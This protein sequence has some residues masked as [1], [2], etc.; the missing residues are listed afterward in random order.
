MQVSHG[1]TGYVRSIAQASRPFTT[2]SPDDPRNF[3][4]HSLIARTAAALA[5][6]VGPSSGAVH[7]V[8]S[9]WRCLLVGVSASAGA[10]MLAPPQVTG[11]TPRRMKRLGSDGD[12]G[13]P[14]LLSSARTARRMMWLRIVETIRSA[15]SNACFV[16][17]DAQRLVAL[18]QAHPPGGVPC[19]NVQSSSASRA[20][21]RH[22]ESAA[23]APVLPVVTPADIPGS[24]V[25]A[26]APAASA[27]PIVAAISIGIIGPA[28]TAIISHHV[29]TIIAAMV[30][31]PS[32]FHPA[33]FRCP[34]GVSGW[35]FSCL[36]PRPVPLS[37]DAGS[38]PGVLVDVAGGIVV[39]MQRLTPVTSVGVDGTSG[40]WDERGSA[41]AER[42]TSGD[43]TSPR[44]PS[45]TMMLLPI[46]DADGYASD[47]GVNGLLI[48][49]ILSSLLRDDGIGIGTPHSSITSRGRRG[50]S[51]QPREADR[52]TTGSLTPPTA[53]G[54][55][56][57]AQC[58]ECRRAAGALSPSPVTPPR[59]A[60]AALL[61]SSV[62]PQRGRHNVSGRAGYRRNARKQM[63][64]LEAAT[65]GGGRPL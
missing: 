18:G 2:T 42:T 48:S 50:I 25:A 32:I 24:I 23:A 15:A 43:L 11:R 65:V 54:L 31:T 1:V 13:R 57:A 33:V 9:R 17:A 14:S 58:H 10:G 6:L 63:P 44:P 7:G 41:A 12:C 19:G 51:G 26:S 52:I 60:A 5:A 8:A 29:T 27:V 38:P 59:A 34:R 3:T 62:P 45:L 46:R 49:V 39:V 20:S 64:P 40:P 37:L 36:T 47:I 22:G 61:S 30:I 56:R 4:P 53:V 21:V 55:R 35:P 28:S 16:A